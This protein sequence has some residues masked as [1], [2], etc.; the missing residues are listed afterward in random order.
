MPPR[1]SRSQPP[2]A[3]PQP[4][5]PSTPTGKIVVT[6]LLPI[7]ALAGAPAVPAAGAALAAA[8][9]KTLAAILASFDTFERK[10]KPQAVERLTSTLTTLYPERTPDEI[11]S[12][13][14]EEMG[15][16]RE[17]QIRQRERLDRD[18]PVALKIVDPVARQAAVE[19]FLARERRY[20]QMREQAMTERAS[21]RAEFLTTKAKS[22]LGAYWMLSD[23]VKQ[24]TPLC[25]AMSGN[26][27]P[28]SVLNVI[29]PRLHAGCFPAG[30]TVFGLRPAGS[31]ARWYSG[32]LVEIDFGSGNHLSVT[33]NH[34]VLTPNGW[35]PAGELHEGN[36]VICGDFAK[37]RIGVDPDEHQVPTLIEQVARTLGKSGGVVTSRVEVAAHHFHGD[38]VGSKVA[39]VRS[40]SELRDRFDSTLEQPSREI[41]LVTRDE[42]AALLASSSSLAQRL[43]AV[44]MTSFGIEGVGSA[45]LAFERGQTR[46]L[47]LRRIAVAADGH[48]A[49]QQ[50]SFDP[51]A[52]M[53]GQF[54]EP[55]HG[56]SASDVVA[57]LRVGERDLSFLVWFD[58][59][60]GQDAVDD[61]EADAEAAR[62]ASDGF[63]G[64]VTFDKIVRVEVREFAGHVYNLET[65]EGWYVA[66]GV[67]VHNCA[68]RLLPLNQ[69]VEMGLMTEKQV[70]DENDAIRRVQEISKKLGGL[71]EAGVTQGEI[72]DFIEDVMGESLAEGAGILYA[73]RY[74]KGTHHGGEFMPKLGGDPGGAARG[75]KLSRRLLRD[76]IPHKPVPPSQRER[77]HVGE[78]KTLSGQRVFVPEHRAFERTMHDGKTFYSPPGSTNVYEQKALLRARPQIPFERG[79]EVTDTMLQLRQQ[80]REEAAAVAR[81]ALEPPQTGGKLP[82][83]I[84]AHPKATHSGML[85]A[86]FNLHRQEINTTTGAITHN[87][88]H[89]MSGAAA[90]VTYGD[91]A[92]QHVEWTPGVAGLE[93]APLIQ[94]RPPE[95]FDEFVTDVFSQAQAIADS[96]GRDLSIGRIVTDPSLADHDGY[97]QWNG[98]IDLGRDIQPAIERV[99]SAHAAGEALTPSEH[100]EAYASIRTAA[101]EA[102]HGI[103]PI[104]PREFNT[105]ALRALEEGLTEEVSQLVTVDMLRRYGMTSTLAWLKANPNDDKAQGSYLLY[106]DALRKIFDQ[107]GL[108][109]DNRQGPTETLKYNIEPGMRLDAL[110]GLVR[111]SGDASQHGSHDQARSEIEHTLS[112]ADTHGRHGGAIVAGFQPI[113]QP[114]LTDVEAADRPIPHEGAEVQVRQPDGTTIPATVVE[115]HQAGSGTVTTVRYADGRVQ[116]YVTPAM[117]RS[118]GGREGPEPSSEGPVLE[119]ARGP[120]AG[121]VMWTGWKQLQSGD[122]VV[123]YR[124]GRV[125]ASGSVQRVSVRPPRGAA[126]RGSSAQNWVRVMWDNGSSGRV[127]DPARTL[128]REGGPFTPEDARGMASPGGERAATHA[129]SEFL[130]VPASG[131]LREPALAALKS[132]DGLLRIPEM[133]GPIPVRTTAGKNKRGGFLRR[134]DAFGPEAPKWDG[135]TVRMAGFGPGQSQ[136][137]AKAASELVPGDVIVLSP[138]YEYTVTDV[139][140]HQHEIGFGRDPVTKVLV[141]AEHT[142]GSPR[143]FDYKPSELVAIHWAPPQ[144]QVPPLPPMY[145][146]EIRVSAAGGDSAFT[147]ES[148]LVHEL[149][150]YIDNQAFLQYPRGGGF[151]SDHAGWQSVGDEK[152]QAA[153]AAMPASIDVLQTYESE[154]APLSDWFTAVN[155]SPEVEALRTASY[156][157]AATHRYLLSPRELFARAF[158]QWVAT[159]SGDPALRTWLADVQGQP[160]TITKYADRWDPETHAMAKVPYETQRPKS[161]LLRQWADDTF[162]PIGAA[163]DSAFGGLGWLHG[164]GSGSDGHAAGD[165]GGGAGPGPGGGS[166]AGL[167]DTGAGAGGVLESV[168]LVEGNPTKPQ[169]CKYGD[170]PATKSLLWAE[171]HAYVPVCD[172]HEADGR[173]RIEVENRDEVLRVIPIREAGDESIAV[174]GVYPRDQ[175]FSAVTAQCDVCGKPAT[176]TVLATSRTR[177]VCDR[178]VETA[179]EGNASA[180]V[181]EL[182]SRVFLDGTKTATEFEHAPHGHPDLQSILHVQEGIFDETLHPRGRHGEWAWKGGSPGELIR[183]ARSRGGKGRKG[184]K[185]PATGWSKKVGELRATPVIGQT[186]LQNEYRAYQAAGGGSKADFNKRYWDEHGNPGGFQTV[187]GGPGSLFEEQHARI[188]EAGARIDAEVN[189]RMKAAVTANAAAKRDLVAAKKKMSELGDAATR[190]SYEAVAKLMV[191]RHDWMPRPWEEMQSRR[192]AYLR[193]THAVHP[194]MA[195]V[196]T[197]Q[198]VEAMWQLRRDVPEAK[199]AL[200][201]QVEFRDRNLLDATIRR[202]Q[203]GRELESARRAHATDVLSE[204][205]P[206]GGFVSADGSPE[207]KDL[208]QQVERF[209]PRDWIA[210][211]NDHP[212]RLVVFQTAERGKYIH[213]VPQVGFEELTSGESTPTS[214][215]MV[216][217]SPEAPGIGIGG[218]T[219]LHEMVHRAEATRDGIKGAEW[220]FYE[221]R[222][223]P[224]RN[225]SKPDAVSLRD[226]TG[227]ESY[228]PEEVTRP[229]D[230]NNPYSGKDY[231]LGTGGPDMHTNYELL[232]MGVEDLATGRNGILAADEEYRQFV[233]GSLALL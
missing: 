138:H 199:A 63:A 26:F 84:G 167:A 137:P 211:S 85:D 195:V 32:S 115:T 132:V 124:D 96:V 9:A 157:E 225:A 33:P 69:A 169:K 133:Q 125:L 145:P 187:S 86:G 152:R 74:A 5:G 91:H 153:L 192:Y 155:D 177:L 11:D 221:A 15:R 37:L 82:A 159:R 150:H 186:W 193:E 28:W 216:S 142:D 80:H 162:V 194:D 227:I 50:K 160:P 175:L 34:P 119:F 78:W 201:A 93:R 191:E 136:R 116:R 158:T 62:K 61:A 18:L 73:L 223:A 70:P 176:H 29:H 8:T 36:H 99:A 203:A 209:L 207:S 101:H 217:G 120:A 30:T 100:R 107:A 64:Q 109:P 185:H 108:E 208:M 163:L 110:A 202:D 129:P 197:N 102:L 94:G 67:I 79:T 181:Q 77:D 46:H 131:K 10:R 174:P 144:D 123:S 206:F 24:S 27:W 134:A 161:L 65:A 31:T 103:N 114:D 41:A 172:D 87:Y 20:V 183:G 219:L 105:P 39:V 19:K 179:K 121:D 98:V 43:E 25:I 118:P 76:L 42:Q 59:G 189:R 229:D 49:A 146:N 214:V 198:D 180:Q 112:L 173:H 230:F 190:A 210:S 66:N 126:A 182:Y 222:T 83:V 68:C 81:R 44:G 75:R 205:R 35:V 170:H 97:H 218:G 171:G 232:S 2:T 165:A 154:P 127:S 148:T 156:A 140:Q 51:V 22:P 56:N 141:N 128:R 48:L 149:A 6:E 143:V 23:H 38:G 168:V 21:A 14:R 3:Q 13:V 104:T 89:P 113:I 226:L 12:L 40:N 231:G 135:P 122:R 212:S 53:S 57:D 60:F 16:D 220:T 147:L 196:Q 55:E 139:S 166:G 4:A 228:K 52:G 215:V 151:A 72:E 58:P 106:R 224:Y 88:V 233:Y 54:V 117:L 47:S 45:L 111:Q 95:S 184:L 90:T 213:A 71:T 130:K 1:P 164:G 200:D 92:V 204:I 17:F 188:M 178:H 7:A